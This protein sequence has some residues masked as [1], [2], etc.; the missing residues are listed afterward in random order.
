MSEC[1][2]FRQKKLLKKKKKSDLCHHVFHQRF[3]QLVLL[4]GRHADVVTLVDETKWHWN[5]EPWVL[6]DLVKVKH[7]CRRSKYFLL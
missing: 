7:V 2:T 4:D 1:E 5:C 6:D 3:L